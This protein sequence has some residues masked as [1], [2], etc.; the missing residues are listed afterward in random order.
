MVGA[1]LSH[2]SDYVSFPTYEMSDTRVVH[3]MRLLPI[4]LSP[5]HSLVTNKCG[6]QH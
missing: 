1:V 5:A 6:S 4:G 2:C 3:S